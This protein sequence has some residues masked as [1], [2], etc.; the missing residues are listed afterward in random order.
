MILF[1]RGHNLISVLSNDVEYRDGDKG[2]DQAVGISP[3]LQSMA[4]YLQNLSG[5]QALL[6]RKYVKVTAR[7]RTTQISVTAQRFVV[8][9]WVKN[10]P[11]H[12]VPPIPWTIL[13]L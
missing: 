5:E 13:Q 8:G 7:V 9:R 11:K 12:Q 4:V 2:L 6:W 10:L 1:H 3:H